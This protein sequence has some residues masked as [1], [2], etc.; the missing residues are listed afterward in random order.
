ML[1]RLVCCT[2]GYNEILNKWKVVCNKM[3]PP[4][5]KRTTRSS[6]IVKVKVE[7]EQLIPEESSTETNQKVSTKKRQK[8]PKVEIKYEESPLEE[9][10]ITKQESS[11]W[12]PPMWREQLKNIY[13]MRKFRNAA[14]D[15]MGC[16]VISDTLASPEVELYRTCST[17][18]R[19]IMIDSLLMQDLTQQ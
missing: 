17:V 4:Y 8:R 2:R 18:I 7:N 6:I 5:F 13:S 10:Q 11:G 12:E 15:S 9:H 3:E 19:S 1:C 16:D 14:V